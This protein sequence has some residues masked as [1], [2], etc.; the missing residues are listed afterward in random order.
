MKQQVSQTSNPQNGHLPASI[1]SH[2]AS[3]IRQFA[4]EARALLHQNVIGEYLFGSY[5]KNTSTSLSDID[6][7]VL[8]NTLTP[9]TRRVLSELAS[10]YSLEYDVYI[11]PIIKDQQVWKKNQHYNTLFYQ[12][13][14]RY[15]IPL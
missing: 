14:T 8:V 1:P 7:L 4:Q 3:I 9:E 13:V 11:S 6:I 10:E 2:I 5:A 12:E 15:G